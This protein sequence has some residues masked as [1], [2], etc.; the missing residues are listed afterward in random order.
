[1]FSPFS[2]LLI[3]EGYP[4][5]NSL[6][7]S[8]SNLIIFSVHILLIYT[9]ANLPLFILVEAC[10]PSLAA[11]IKLT[12]IKLMLPKLQMFNLLPGR[13]F[14]RLLRVLLPRQINTGAAN[15][16]IISFAS[17][18]LFLYDIF[19]QA[20]MISI[21]GNVQAM[22]GFVAGQAIVAVSTVLPY[23]LR[24]GSQRRII[25]PSAILIGYVLVAGIFYIFGDQILQTWIGRQVTNSQIMFLSFMAMY[26]FEVLSG[27]YVNH[28]YVREKFDYLKAFAGLL[29]VR[30][31]AFWLLLQF[32]SN[33]LIIPISKAVTL[34]LI[35]TL[36]IHYNSSKNEIYHEGKNYLA[37]TKI[38]AFIF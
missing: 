26:F 7:D 3:A 31:V 32:Y 2:G 34:A 13:A 18:D 38:P 30:V 33:P 24:Y 37:V 19:F 14:W 22:F 16:M 17:M 28:L 10:R 36:F 8:L 23:M 1:M 9:G 25:D 5:W 35:W 27:L 6:I 4:G 21:Y 12:V 15:L 11:V 29:L 20:K